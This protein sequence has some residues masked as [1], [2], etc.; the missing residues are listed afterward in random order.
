M[1]STPELDHTPA[2]KVDSEEAV[3]DVMKQYEFMKLANG[4][5]PGEKPFIWPEGDRPDIR[6]DEYDFKLPI[7]DLSPVLKLH[8]LRREIEQL[9]GDGDV[10]NGL[11]AEIK[12]CE[13]A[14][15]DIAKAIRAACE[16]YGFF[17]IFN[18]G[19]PNEVVEQFR[20]S[21]RQI[22]DLPL[23]E[24]M[25]IKQTPNPGKP[26]LPG[27]TEMK[28]ITALTSMNPSHTWSESF[29][30]ES[31]E[32]M[33][34][35][36]VEEIAKILW[37]ENSTTG[38]KLSSSVEE[39]GKEASKVI[40]IL[41]DLIAASL[42]IPEEAVDSL[43]GDRQNKE[44]SARIR[45]NNYPICERP[46]LT[47]GLKSHTDPDVI[48]LLHQDA[49]GGLQIRFKDG[50]WHGV[51]PKAGAF[52]IN[53]G[54]FLQAWTNGR[55]LSAEHQVVGND[56][57]RRMSIAYFALSDMNYIINPRPECVDAEHPVRYKPFTRLEHIKQLVSLGLARERGKILDKAFGIQT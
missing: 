4:V 22:F 36:R 2:G 48:T 23:E 3:E 25:K 41:L 35:G 28:R 40:Y 26:S 24:K 53:C 46:E 14:K 34:P 7:I 51:Q 20:E 50:T 5:Q 29:D 43:L 45:V 11:E 15:S 39:Y 54:N 31:P 56:K 42:G 16:E 37:P 57:T 30:V 27:Y 9:E 49:V 52:I 6:H 8:S 44:V 1:A 18:S 33:F 12:A 47:W 55:F 17:Q 38:Q 13:A 32:R 10:R 19:F 21:C